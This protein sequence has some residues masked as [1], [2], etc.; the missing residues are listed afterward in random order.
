M[1]IFLTSILMA[2]LHHTAFAQYEYEPSPVHPFGI[3]NPEAPGELL[4]FAPL[5][6]ECNCSS[7]NRNPD[8]SWAQPVEML[9]RFKY[10]MNGLAIQ[11]ETLKMDGRH[12]GSIRQFSTDSTRW[13]VHYY[14]SASVAPVLSTWEGGKDEDGRIVLYN[15]QK[16]PNGL[17]G[18]YKITFSGINEDGFQWLG[19][20]VNTD[21]SFSFPTWKI[22]CTKKKQP[23]QEAEKVHI[24]KLIA[25]FSEAYMAGDY[26]TLAG[27]YSEDGKI[28]PDRAGIIEGRQAIKDRWVLPEGAAILDHQV[29]PVTINILGEYAYDYGYFEGKSK[30]VKGDM[31][32]W[33]GKYV[34]VWKKVAGQWKIY[35]DIWN[36]VTD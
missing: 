21:E 17:D 18:F 8:N 14:S 24:K 12:S 29:T 15:Q 28:F 1:K 22:N 6:G 19:E 2:M 23:G 36:R 9:W 34:I 7:Q 13:Y 31:A 26:D 33:K 27:F 32:S 16:A 35:L 30:N 4:D 10:I 5:I 20:W 25:E 3:P 11:D